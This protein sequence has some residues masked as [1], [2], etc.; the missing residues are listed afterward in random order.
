M[1][2]LTDRN[3]ERAEK[4]IMKNI[5]VKCRQC[6]TTMWKVFNHNSYFCP[7]CER[8]LVRGSSKF[9]GAPGYTEY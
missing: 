5:K 4:E 9:G 8:Y 6:K 2:E 3:R 7:N 1:S